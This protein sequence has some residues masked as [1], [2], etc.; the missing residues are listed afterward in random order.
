MNTSWWWKAVALVSVLSFLLIG[1]P[2]PPVPV[3]AQPKADLGVPS[4]PLPEAADF[5]TLTFQNSWDM[6]QFSDISQYLNGAGRHVT[7]AD[8]NVQ[9]GVFSARSLGDYHK[10][11]AFFFPLYSGYDNFIQVGFNNG[12]LY[13]IDP[14]KYGCLYLAMKVD[15]P[16]FSFDGDTP[17][18]GFR[19][20]WD[21]GTDN[22]SGGTFQYLYPETVKAPY[23]KVVNRWRLYEVNL[24]EPAGGLYANSTAWSGRSEWRGLQVTPTILK[25][26]KFSVDWI[27]LTSCK[28]DSRFQARIDFRPNSQV[29]SL[30]VRPAGTNRQIEVATD[31]DGAKGA[32]TLD[33][34]GLP[35]GAY[36]VGVGTLTDC[37]SEWSNTEL[38]I[39]QT[40]LA[41]FIK[42]SPYSGE[43]Y[44]QSAGNAW[45]MDASDINQ[46]A[47][48][49]YSFADGVLTL[50]TKPPS[51]LSGGCLGSIGEADPRLMLNMPGGSNPVANQYRYLSF[52]M[53]IDGDYAVP[54]D[55]MMGRWMWRTSDRCTQVSADIPY[56]I[57]WRTYT[58]DLYDVF[59]GTPVGASPDS[60]S[61]RTWRDTGEVAQFRFDPNENYTGNLVPEMVFHQEFDWIRLTKVDRVAQGERF[62]VQIKLNK[63]ENLLQ[64]IDF[65]YTTDRKDP[66]MFPAYERVTTRSTNPRIQRG[67]F[68]PLVSRNMTTSVG[69]GQEGDKVFYWD[70]GSVAKGEYY[71]CARTS[72]GY[73][74][75][76][77]CSEAPVKVY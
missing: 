13:P 34:R 74:Q 39:N 21:A 16:Q 36:D 10:D 3:L 30:W 24:Y 71:I 58:I 55:G 29:T 67:I 47:C 27:R 61:T 33:T 53:R 35:P 40:P 45:D 59:N 46:V 19:V 62:P 41:S 76:T 64:S 63:A 56:D 18:D 20:F 2:Q 17:P 68:L 37:C 44:A 14:T 22:V 32:Y 8:V 65:F 51:A 6:S 48:S 75:A 50:D 66:T 60:C 57:G 11:L 70:T 77:T 9:D 31:V 15:S 69:S 28:D 25:N 26:V 54:A 72:D 49:D 43:D 5:A 52:R 23:A 38:R 73:N 7:L 12:S 1:V 4:S 42:P